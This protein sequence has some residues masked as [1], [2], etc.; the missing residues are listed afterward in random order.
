MTGSTIRVPSANGSGG[1]DHTAP[2]AITSSGTT[3]NWWWG[4]TWGAS[5]VIRFGPIRPAHGVTP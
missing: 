2:L 5:G 1:G 3:A 4:R